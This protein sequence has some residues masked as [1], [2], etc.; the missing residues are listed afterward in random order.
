MNLLEGVRGLHISNPVLDSN[1][2]EIHFEPISHDCDA[3]KVRGKTDGFRMG[4]DAPDFRLMCEIKDGVAHLSMMD[5]LITIRMMGAVRKRLREMGV[6][7]IVLERLVRG[8][9]RTME[10]KI[11]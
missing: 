5:G 8:K 11:R 3:Y 2:D 4:E 9:L 7:K 10:G 6:K 1:V